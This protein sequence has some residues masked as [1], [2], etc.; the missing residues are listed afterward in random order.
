MAQ[1]RLHLHEANGPLPAVCMFCGETSTVVIAEK[2]VWWPRWTY[3][4]FFVHPFLWAN[5]AWCASRS[6]WV[7]A[8]FC[9]RHQRHWQNR[10]LSIWS[11][12]TVLVGILSGIAFIAVA[13]FFE[14]GDEGMAIVIY[15]G[16]VSLLAIWI[17]VIV[18]IHHMTIRPSVI[19]DTEIVIQGVAESFVQAVQEADR[20]RLETRS[21]RDN[22]QVTP[23]GHAAANDPGHLQAR[24]PEKSPTDAIE[25]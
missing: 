12:G 4:F 19:T 2:L 9:S 25:E 16:G 22:A 15:L 11:A 17:M 6:A 20:E 18:F 23:E 10:S 5:V 8:P 14:L 1:V 13:K 3:V 24:M 7:Q 21:A